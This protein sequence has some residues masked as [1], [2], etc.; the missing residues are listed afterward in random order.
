[1]SKSPVKAITQA[2]L[3]KVAMRYLERYSASTASLRRVL[4]RRVEG[5]VRLGLSDGVAEALMVEPLILRLQAMGL[6]DD[7]RYAEGKAASLLGRGRSM[8]AI[9]HYLQDRGVA[10][11]NI[12]PVLSGLAAED[13]EGSP[14]LQAARNYARKRRLGPH[15]PGSERSLHRLRDLAALGRAGFSW[16]VAQAVIDAEEE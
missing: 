12:D 4:L 7:F 16:A 2:Y 15:R 1:M 9:R 10:A 14:D 3:E 11:E 13:E 6:L 8:R 5:A